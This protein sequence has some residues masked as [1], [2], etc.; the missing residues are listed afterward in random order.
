MC[1]NDR[2]CKNCLTNLHAKSRETALPQMWRAWRHTAFNPLSR[3]RHTSSQYREPLSPS[4]GD[5]IYGQPLTGKENSL[6][7]FSCIALYGLHVLTWHLLTFM[8]SFVG[9]AHCYYST[10]VWQISLPWLYQVE[11]RRRGFR[12]APPCLGY[13]VLLTC[14]SSVGGNHGGIKYHQ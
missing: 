6:V 5:V 8:S 12:S 10:G 9:A 14:I 2:C 7:R 11:L 13:A 1:R 4:A 3:L